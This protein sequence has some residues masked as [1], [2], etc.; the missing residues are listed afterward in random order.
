MAT[1]ESF[2]GT[3]NISSVTS[4][5]VDI[6][7]VMVGARGAPS[8]EY[9]LPR[10]LGHDAT[11][12][13]LFDLTPRGVGTRQGVWTNGDAASFSE[14]VYAV[15]ASVGMR[16]YIYGN[17]VVNCVEVGREKISLSDENDSIDSREVLGSR[18]CSQECFI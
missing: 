7:E 10:K 13:S 3:S 11:R 15:P 14:Y 5:F 2:S 12:L 4:Q 1:G 8:V 9:S 17:Y 16:E 6:E 18:E